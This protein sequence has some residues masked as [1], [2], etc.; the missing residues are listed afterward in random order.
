METLQSQ[1]FLLYTRL[2]NASNRSPCYSIRRER[3]HR[4]AHLAFARYE[5]RRDK[6]SHFVIA[7]K[8]HQIALEVEAELNQI[9]LEVEAELNQISGGLARPLVIPPSFPLQ[10]TPS[11]HLDCFCSQCLS[12][13][14]DFSR[15]GA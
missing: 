10:R 6:Y 13:F 12:F 1:A 7:H 11:R 15:Q 3:L 5:R 14:T 4:L 2:V 8:T 9:A